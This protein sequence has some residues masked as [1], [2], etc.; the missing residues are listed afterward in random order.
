[1]PVATT[2]PEP[3]T[4]ERVLRRE[5]RDPRV[6][7]RASCYDCVLRS[8]DIEMFGVRAPTLFVPIGK[9]LAA[10][11]LCRPQFGWRDVTAHWQ[12]H[13][14][15]K[16]DPAA[17]VPEPVPTSGSEPI[18]KQLVTS[19]AWGRLQRFARGHGVPTLKRKRTAI[20][21]DLLALV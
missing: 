7:W 8:R 10:D 13:L 2:P 18:T 1:M 20:E 15:G 19:M 4:Y 16:Q 17:P 21:A 6:E 5:D 14:D 11:R 3:G 12:A 9:D